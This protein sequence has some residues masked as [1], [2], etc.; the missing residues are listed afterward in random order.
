MNP[1]IGWRVA[2]LIRSVLGLVI[3]VM[4]LWI[5]ESPRWLMTHGDVRARRGRMMAGGL[6]VVVLVGEAR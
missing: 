1:A 5:P 6:L 2:F 3:L 4:R